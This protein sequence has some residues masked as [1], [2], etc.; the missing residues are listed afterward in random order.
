MRMCRQSAQAILI[1]IAAICSHL[2]E[3]TAEDPRSGLYWLKECAG[4][5]TLEVFNCNAII[6]G[7]VGFHGLEEVPQIYCPPAGVKLEQ[8]K[9]VILKYLKDNPAR[10][11]ESFVRLAVDAFKAAWPCR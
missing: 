10:L 3:A 6:I 5:S 4:V 2:N 1:A 11:H 7:I 9:A 8:G